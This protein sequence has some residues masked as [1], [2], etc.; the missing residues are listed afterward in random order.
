M[1]KIFKGTE[2]EAETEADAEVE[3]GAESKALV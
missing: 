3:T 2:V 1:N